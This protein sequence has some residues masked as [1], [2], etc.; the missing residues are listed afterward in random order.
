MTDKVDSLDAARKARKAKQSR[1]KAE[2]HMESKSSLGE[3]R[4]LP[5]RNPE[6]G[7][8]KAGDWEPTKT[9]L[10]PHCPIEALGYDGPNFYFLDGRGVVTCLGAK[11]GKG[12]IDALFTPYKNFPVWAWPRFAGKGKDRSVN[13]NFDAERVR[14]DLFA[15]CAIAGSW[16]PQERVRGRG[17]WTEEDGTLVL[18]LGDVVETPNGP[19]APG[20]IGDYVYP[21]APP[22]VRP[23]PFEPAGVDSAGDCLLRLMETWNWMRGVTDARLALGW[24]FL[25]PMCGATSWRPYIFLT[26]DQGSGK[27]TWMKLVEIALNGSLLKSEDATEAGI[28]QTL[29]HDA[30]PV[31]LDELEQDNQDS[32]KAQNIV[33]MARRAASGSVR[34]RGGQDHKASSFTI[35][36][37][38][39]FGAINMPSMGDQDMARMAVLCLKPFT[40]NTKRSPFDG[41]EVAAYGQALFGRSVAWWQM[42]KGLSRF[43]RLLDLVRGALIEN[44][45]HDDRGADT[46]GYLLAG[47]W[48]ATNDEY[49]DPEALAEFTDPLAKTKLAEYESIKAGWRKCVDYMLAVQPRILD[50][51]A[52]KSVGDI[53]RSWRDDPHNVDEGT[54]KRQLALVGLTLRYYKGSPRQYDYACLFVPRSHPSVAALF[55]GT[56]WRAHDPAGDGGWSTALRGGPDDTFKADKVRVG[57]KHPVRGTSITVGEIVGYPKESNFYDKAHYDE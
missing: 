19:R 34:I 17:A 45:G 22:M 46:F 23:A 9:G 52:N 37:S 53:L 26:G 10:P 31:A 40:E 14:Q 27:T 38:F 18:H 15:A 44:G 35:R 39:V 6:L 57:T 25:A 5:S 4:Q 48:A 32:R 41:A 21:A 12:D 11:T 8:V 3:V 7:G 43:V 28:A 50:R 29:G 49:P 55:E 2:I 24:L 47:Y 56:H 30:L 20:L 33:N 42:D 36:S 13:G 54:V 51:N 16:T 1:V